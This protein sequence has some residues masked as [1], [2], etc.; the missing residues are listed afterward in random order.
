MDP[1]ESWAAVSVGTVVTVTGLLFAAFQ[2]VDASGGASAIDLRVLLLLVAAFS[3][4]LGGL[5]ILTERPATEPVLRVLA[6]WGGAMAVT[7]LMAVM[8]LDN[9][10]K[11]GVNIADPA[12]VRVN[13]LTVGSTGGLLVGYFYTSARRTAAALAEQTDQLRREKERLAVLQRLIGHDVRND[14]HLVLAWSDVLGDA[15]SADQRPTVERIHARSKHVVETTELSS[16]F[17]SMMVD[18]GSMERRPVDLA[19]V[20][21]M[22]VDACRESYPDA[23]F[24]V[25]GDLPSVDVTANDLLHSVFRN[26]LTN[27]VQH[28]D[29]EAPTVEITATRQDDV[30]RVAIADDGPGVPDEKKRAVFGKGELGIDSPG[31]GLGLYLVSVLVDEYGGS[32]WIEDNDPTGS[33]V[34][35]ELVVSD[36]ESW[37]AAGEPQITTD[38]R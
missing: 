22:E 35:V 32:V 7:L 3:T 2:L 38:G 30:V 34:V 14:M 4:V 8:L 18:D 25:A 5:W 28:N 27:A 1:R 10:A 24:V 12:A 31:T 6:W 29:A 17:V 37:R 16:D 33:R 11:S 21:A 26:V 20:L 23:E 19:E 36:G 13:A 9:Q 15:V